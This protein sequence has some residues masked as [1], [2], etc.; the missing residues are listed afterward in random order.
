[1]ASGKGPIANLIGKVNE[2]NELV[3]EAT[4]NVTAAD[5]SIVDGAD[6]LIKATVKDYTNANPLAVVSVD[7]NGD[8]VAAG[9][10]TQYNQGTASTD[11]DTGTAA[12]VVRKDTPAIAT[13]VADGDRTLLS[14]DAV[15]QLYARLRQQI[16]ADTGGGTVAT[17]VVVLGLP[18]AGGPV[19][20]I[21]GAGAVSTQVQR[22]TLASDDPAV[23]ALQVI[24]DW[25][26]SDRAKVNP[27]VG[28]AGVAAGA[29]A[30]GATVQRTTLASDDPAVV[31]LQVMD[32][33]DESDRAK[34]NLIVGQA[35]IAGG[36]GADGATVP[37]VSLATN[38]ALPAGTNLLGRASASAE[39]STVY[40]ATTA[41]TPKFAVIAASSSGNNTLVAAVGGA[42]IRVLA[43]NFI[44]NGTV[45]A[46]FQSGAGGTDLTGLKY[47]VANMGL[48]APFNPVGWFETASNTLLNLNLSA[49]IA[50]GGELVYVEV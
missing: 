34:V 41:L 16:D 32:D 26:E 17:D 29:G 50:V 37:R 2:N 44:A 25:D 19:A 20:A 47:C 14:V 27:I 15:G 6:P 35:G 45:N 28:Q 31:A 42:K 22:T 5:G 4:V 9:G 18:A 40:N 21:G 1:M 8:Y 33:W 3:V 46:K 30:V 11:T 39:T 38:V 13:G 12:I 10:G 24:D 36:T 48:C 49:A 43:Y 7:T 23:V